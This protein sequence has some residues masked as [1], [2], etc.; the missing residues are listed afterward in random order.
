MEVFLSCLIYI[1]I[2]YNNTEYTTMIDQLQCN[3]IRKSF[4]QKKCE[5][6]IFYNR[7]KFKLVLIFVFTL[8]TNT[9]KTAEYMPLFREFVKRTIKFNSLSC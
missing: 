1:I 4:S 2:T 5:L 8:S 9:L 6:F 3:Y 7:I